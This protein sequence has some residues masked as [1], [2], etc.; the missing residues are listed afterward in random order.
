M[1]N[2][3]NKVPG[4]QKIL[5]HF[6][7]GQIPTEQHYADLVNSMIHKDE[8]GFSKDDINGFKIYSE[9]SFNKLV[10]F[11]SNTNATDPFFTIAKDKANP[12]GF[13]IQ[14]LVEQSNTDTADDTGVFFH[15]NGN[16]G[17][18]KKPDDGF[19]IDIDG[20][21]AG[22]GRIGTYAKQKAIPADGHWSNIAGPLLNAQA[23]EVVARTGVKNTGKL[24]IMHA[25]ALSVAG[26]RG[27]KIHKRNSYVGW[28]WNRINLRWMG[29]PDGYYLQMKTNSNYGPGIEIYYTISQLW[30]DRLFFGM[31]YYNNDTPTDSK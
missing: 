27:G 1:T 9:N 14:S 11:Y 4:R 3:T 31:D 15:T 8:D 7:N 16:L 12:D 30:D 25:I 26:K 20:F 21:V 19:K 6:R 18:G 2:K 28:F 13:K 29:D 24:A 22:K 5:N 23:F 10:S 17:V